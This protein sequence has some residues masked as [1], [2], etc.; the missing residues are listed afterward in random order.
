MFFVLSKNSLFYGYKLHAVYSVTVVFH[1]LDITKAE[2]FDVHFL[3][4]IKQQMS[5]YMLLGDRGYLS[6][7][8]QLDLFHSANINLETSKRMNQVNYKPKPYISENPEKE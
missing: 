5:D 1:S 8:N 3:K 4:N 2:V 7:S 6:K